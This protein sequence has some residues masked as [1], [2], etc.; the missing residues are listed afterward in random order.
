MWLLASSQADLIGLV[1]ELLRSWD[2]RKKNFWLI[3]TL[4]SL[5]DSVKMESLTCSTVPVHQDLPLAL[6]ITAPISTSVQTSAHVPVMLTVRMCQD[7]IIAT[8]LRDSYWTWQRMQH[9]M[10]WT[11]V[12]WMDLVMSTHHVKIQWKVTRAPAMKGMQE[13]GRRVQI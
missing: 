6:T 7:H 4:L 3:Q 5:Q 8:A 11:N 9:V 13:M 1:N 2:K 10:M 12:R